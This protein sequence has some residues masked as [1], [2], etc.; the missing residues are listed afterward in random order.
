MNT[1]TN[2]HHAI[3][4]EECVG[5][6]GHSCPGLAFG[7]RA[8]TAAMKAL[9]VDRPEDEELVAIC[10]TNA[11]GVDAIQ[12][13]AGTT[14]GKG[15]LVVYDYGKHVFTFFNRK[16]G[17]AVR[18]RILTDA[19]TGNKKFDALRK[20]VFSGKP[21]KSEVEQFN[22]MKEAAT[23]HVLTAPQDKVLELTE[24]TIRPPRMARI[25]ASIDCENCGE[26][27]ADKKTRLIKG[28][29]VCIPCAKSMGTQKKKPAAGKA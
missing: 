18:V 24:V 21:T 26:A 19:T 6:H 23:S 5:F 25:F 4:Y 8:V 13:V 2:K 28:K 27:V 29:R 12:A 20:K 7:Y 9:G 1:P 3:T 14:A 17:R 15:N 10:E 11:C 16:N 22:K